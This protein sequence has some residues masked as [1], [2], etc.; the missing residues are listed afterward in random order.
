M[1]AVDENG[2][3][4]AASQNVP[5][6]NVAPTISL[7]GPSSANQGQTLHYTFS[8]TDPG[9]LD[10]FTFVAGSP[11]GGTYGTV[12]NAVIHPDG[13]GSLDVTF[14]TLPGS[15]TTNVTVQDQ[16]NAGAVSNLASITVTIANPLEVTNF[17]TNPSGFD[18]TFNRAPEF[19]DLNLYDG[20]KGSEATVVI[21]PAD[22]Q[23]TRTVGATSTV[24]SGSMVW[25]AATN[26]MSW[27]KTGGV[28]ADNVDNATYTVTLFSGGTAFHDTTANGSGDLDGNGDFT[29]TAGDNYMNSFAV[30]ATSARV[31]S[32]HD[33]ARGPGQHVDDNPAGS[34]TRLAVSIDNAADV[35]SLDFHFRYD[36]AYLTV[37]G[38]SLASGLPAGWSITVNNTTPG[39]LIITTSGGNKLSGTHVPVVLIDA[40]VATG[41]PYLGAEILQFQGVT[42]GVEDAMH[43]VN[44]TPTLADR[45]LQ[46]VVFFGDVNGDQFYDGQDSSLISRVFV[47]FDTG[48]AGTDWTDPLI[49][50]DVDNSGVINGID[51]S[52]VSGEV[53]HPALTPQIPNV[54][55]A[56]TA[57]APPGVD[58]TLTIDDN[59]PVGVSGAVTIPVKITIDPDVA[60]SSATFTV[61]YDP[62]KLSFDQAATAEGGSFST[63]AFDTSDSSPAGTI[64]VNMF[65][66]V[67]YTTGAAPE[68]LQL[69]T[70][71]FNV[72]VGTRG[73]SSPLAISPVNPHQGGLTWTQDDGSVV[74]ELV[75][76]YN[77]NG[78]VDM[79]DY[80][81]WRNSTGSS[82]A[83]Y[84]GADGNGDGVVDANDYAVWRSHFGNS[85]P[86]AGSGALA[87]AST[88][89]LVSPASQSLPDRSVGSAAEMMASAAESANPL[90]SIA[91]VPATLVNRQAVRDAALV[92]LIESSNGSGPAAA[93]AIKPRSS[94]NVTAT[95]QDLTELLWDLAA[96]DKPAQEHSYGDDSHCESSPQ[97]T[98]VAAVDELFAEFEDM[99]SKVAAAV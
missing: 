80:V 25:N 60:L 3:S 63:W 58:P 57:F 65:D 77:R 24:V 46:K 62:T 70:L 51:A 31:V 37:Q 90:P 69:A 99:S 48:F 8:T 55:V 12:S 93:L 23:V 72:L 71:A 45:A 5:I 98:H 36:P 96:A 40:F 79:A 22:I 92:G 74:F 41:A 67:G 49:V 18:V 53:L 7:L 75:G 47:G 73:G 95:T 59:I 2:L 52:I 42:V 10:T 82:V 15:H 84:S 33:F 76:D 21:N 66:A 14:S 61:T 1:T 19:A 38:A 30:G 91:N 64:T 4:S 56:P 16:D 17:V 28:L 20:K 86:G 13:T 39:D 94:A 68:T 54:V 11:D 6:S 32:V 44:S 78:L 97:D 89:S 26:T 34:L 87:I 27:I 35:R 29:I 81:L 50:G 85:A 9:V 43:N 83:A 88:A